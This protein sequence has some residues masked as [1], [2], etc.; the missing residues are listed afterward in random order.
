M[1]RKHHPQMA[2]LLEWAYH[3]TCFPSQRNTSPGGRVERGC[4]SSGPQVGFLSP[5]TG[6][7]SGSHMIQGVQMA[8]RKVVGFPAGSLHPEGF[9]PEEG[10]RSPCRS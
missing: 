4:G 3:I 2:G 7:G 8:R 9:S 10:C 6:R 1:G 5:G